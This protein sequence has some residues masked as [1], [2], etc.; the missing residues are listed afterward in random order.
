LSRELASVRILDAKQRSSSCGFHTCKLHRLPTISLFPGLGFRY[1]FFGLGSLSLSWWF[2]RSHFASREPSVHFIFTSGCFVLSWFQGT[3][4]CIPQFSLLLVKSKDRSCSTFWGDYLKKN[5]KCRR[6][7]VG[8]VAGCKVVTFPQI[9]DAWNL[10]C[11]FQI[12]TLLRAWSFSHCGLSSPGGPCLH[13][14]PFRYA[15]IISWV[16]KTQSYNDSLRLCSS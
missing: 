11:L 15:T 14:T 1:P 7:H 3:L 6:K 4:A 16:V 9:S 2:V 5:T 10:D 13:G 12:N 8:S